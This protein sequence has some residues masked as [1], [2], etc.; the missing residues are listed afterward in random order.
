MWSFEHVVDYAATLHYFVFTHQAQGSSPVSSL[1]LISKYNEL[2]TMK[3]FF[4]VVVIRAVG[5][6]CYF[7]Q[8]CLIFPFPCYNSYWLLVCQ[9]CA[10]YAQSHNN[11]ESG[12]ASHSHLVSFS[13]SGLATHVKQRPTFNTIEAPHRYNVQG[14]DT[15]MITRAASLPGQ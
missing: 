9:R 7:Q 10:A 3:W 11:G 1:L 13:A 8:H 14:S 12:P 6:D 5:C 15:T 4:A 2:Q